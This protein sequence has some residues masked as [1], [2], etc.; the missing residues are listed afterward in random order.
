[1]KRTIR[2]YVLFFLFCFVFFKSN[3]ACVRIS[4]DYIRLIH[5]DISNWH[6]V[7]KYEFSLVEF[8]QLK[9]IVKNEQNVYF[10]KLVQIKVMV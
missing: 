8:Q 6:S 10:S 5:I 9:E 3:V 1:M 4:F 2:M 7:C